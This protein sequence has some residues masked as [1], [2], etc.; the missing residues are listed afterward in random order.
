MNH[1][2]TK[3]QL[4]QQAAGFIEAHHSFLV[5][6]HV[7]PDGDAIG[8]TLAVAHLLK[9]FGKQYVLTNDSPVPEKYRF[10]D[11]AGDIL[12][13]EA[14]KSKGGFHA[15]IS[16]DAADRQRLGA[17][18][19][20]LEQGFPLLNIDHHPTND[21][22]GS[23][24]VVV[25]DKAATAEIL[26]ELIEYL[27]L[28]WDQAFAEAVY[29]GVMTDT[30]GFRYSNTTPEVMKLA[31]QLLH[32]GVVPGDIADRVFE[33]ISYAKVL[34]LKEALNSLVVSDDGQ[35]AWLSITAEQMKQTGAKEEDLGGIVNLA[36]NVEGVEVG[37]LLKQVDERG[38]KV[39]LRSRKKVDVAKVAKELGGGGHARA[40]GCYVEGSLNEVEQTVLEAARRALALCQTT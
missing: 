29:T 15:V 39:S 1:P 13:W 33:T 10:L 12:P 35:I 5:V 14:A 32:Y 4:W 34:I 21:R 20:V 37:I 17:V 18:E 2:E 30:G 24:N 3:R 22:F 6:S 36:R 25:D 27:E 40:A 7:Q 19:E 16:V 28:E 38:V 9:Q 8:S 31:A 23:V 26:Y 11:M